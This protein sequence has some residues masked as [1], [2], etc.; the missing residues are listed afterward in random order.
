MTTLE[1]TESEISMCA[2]L[3]LLQMGI[4]SVP[5]S[6][7]RLQF[8]SSTKKFVEIL[9]KNVDTDNNVLIKSILG[10]L[11]HLLRVQE[12]AQWSNQSTFDVFNAILAFALHSKPKIRKAAQNGIVAILKGSNFMSEEG[13]PGHHPAA[14]HV[15][16]YCIKQIEGSIGMKTMQ[17]LML[18]TLTL[19]KD[20]IHTFPKQWIKVC[21]NQIQ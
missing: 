15:A 6:V 12:L 4:K 3:S 10:V 17:T 7:L 1:A 8:S 11:T 18:H 5:V 9:N 16:Q 20:V 14:A 21:N 19:L 13:A 2:I